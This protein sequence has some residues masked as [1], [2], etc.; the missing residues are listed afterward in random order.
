[1]PKQ[2]IQDGISSIHQDTQPRPPKRRRR[3][4]II[5]KRRQRDGSHAIHKEH[6]YNVTM[7]QAVEMFQKRSSTPKV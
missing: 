6:L 2:L 7:S 4:T 3:V 1:V 5:R